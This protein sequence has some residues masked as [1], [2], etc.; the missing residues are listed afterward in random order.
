MTSKNLFVAVSVVLFSAPLFADDNWP[1]FRGPDGRAVA[2]DHPALPTVWSKT[3]NVAWTSEIPG[4]G[5]ASPVVWGDKVFIS[6]V[7]SDGEKRQP[8]KGL[9]LGQGVRDPSKGLHHWWVLCFDLDS[10]KEIWRHE[11]HVGEPKVP[12]HPKSTYAAETPVTDGKHLYVLFGDVGLY[13]YSLDGDLIWSKSI[14]PKRTFMDYGA[15]ASPVVHE[16]QVFVV[17]D[18]LE[19][20]WIASFD[21][22]TGEQRWRKPRNEKR[23]W[24][25]PL[26]WKNELRTELVVPGLNRNR[27][28]SLSG[29][30]LWQFDG[31]MSSLVIPSPFA[32]HGMV[33]V[34]SGYVGDAHR[35]T[36]AIK[37]GASGELAKGDYD[38]SEFIAWYQPTASPYNTS[39]IVVGEFLYTLYDQGFLTCHNAKTG[40]EVFGKR[41]FPRGASFTSSPWAYNGKLFCL[42]EDGET[43][44]LPASDEFKVQ[45]T[46][47]LGEMCAACPAVSG[48]KLLIRTASKL[49]CLTKKQ[50]DQDSAVDR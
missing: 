4:W 49:Y 48:D 3:K 17:Y 16:R 37:P 18:N 43:Y 21:A 20:S 19:N 2:P 11:A 38:D 39:Q 36:F 27:S 22:E 25:T 40:E 23:S 14:E 42:S 31:D 33:Y 35:P 41:R 47:S 29:E 8:S 15:A 9:Y 28:Y 50:G 10:G 45:Q 24:A 46:N 13:C 7:V 44:V 30:V 12:R 32:A 1:R 5:W 34:A 6:T 26:V